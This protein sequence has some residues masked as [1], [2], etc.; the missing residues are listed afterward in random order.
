ME[1]CGYGRAGHSDKSMR[2][3]SPP[4]APASSCSSPSLLMLP[5]RP[6]GPALAGRGSMLEPPAPAP[7][8]RA[9]VRADD[10]GQSQS[11]RAN[12]PAQRGRN[13]ERQSSDPRRRAVGSGR[14]QQP[15]TTVRTLLSRGSKRRHGA[16]SRPEFISKRAQGRGPHTSQPPD[17]NL[18]PR[19]LPTTRNAS[20]R[21]ERSSHRNRSL[22]R[23]AATHRRRRCQA[24]A[25]SGPVA[26]VWRCVCIL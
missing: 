5:T 26:Q 11:P 10:D 2:A 8:P 15:S 24:L 20:H 6:S 9:W 18:A 25:V 12:P 14:R 7:A 16:E 3:A 21:W 17:V 4:G 19:S 1:H 23:P 13:V 22:V